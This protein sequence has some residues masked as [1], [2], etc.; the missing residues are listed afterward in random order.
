MNKGL[1]SIRCTKKLVKTSP[2]LEIKKGRNFVINNRNSYTPSN[3]KATVS[4][5]LDI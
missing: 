2:H 4:S 5:D 3:S 1:Q